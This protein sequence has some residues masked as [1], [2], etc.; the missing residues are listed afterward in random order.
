AAASACSKA[1]RWDLA[2]GILLPRLLPQPCSAAG[3]QKQ[4]R[5]QHQ[6]LQEEHQQQ[7][8]KHQ[9]EQ[10]HQV[11]WQHPEQLEH[12]KQQLN[13]APATPTRHNSLAGPRTSQNIAVPQDSSSTAY[14]RGQEEDLCLGT[15]AGAAAL[16]GT[17]LSACARGHRWQEALDLLLKMGEGQV[18]PNVACRSS[19]M[20]ACE[21]ASQWH[22]ALALL[23]RGSM[24]HHPGLQE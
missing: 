11:A 22:L 17:A 20:S 12:L 7:F 5:S 1:S 2:L 13:P 18:E 8:G 15:Q 16:W 6:H 10:E 19:A 4:Q 23:P 21:R 14:Q 24:M 3:H 9:Q